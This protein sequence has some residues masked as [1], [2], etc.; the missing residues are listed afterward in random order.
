MDS[1]L[2]RNVKS[3]KNPQEDFGLSEGSGNFGR[4]LR[5]VIF[6]KI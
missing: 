4:I 6:D 5:L 1:K 2:K 3:D